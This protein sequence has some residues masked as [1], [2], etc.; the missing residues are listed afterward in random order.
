MVRLLLPLAAGLALIVAAPAAAQAVD[1][2]IQC[3]IA[4]NIFASV[5]KDPQKKQFSAAAALF[6]L[7]RADARMNTA[8]MESRIFAQKALLTAQ[9]AG[10]VMT[11]CAR[12]F[13]ARQV[14][15]QEIAK[16]IAA[17]MP[18]KR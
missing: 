14:A 5:E 1:Q 7:G 17:K 11:G 15:M 12:Q 8:Q 9:N 2:D 6:F 3:M 16:H 10:A 4:S 18:A 13:Q